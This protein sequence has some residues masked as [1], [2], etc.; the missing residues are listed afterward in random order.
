MPR[1]RQQSCCPHHQTTRSVT[2]RCSVSCSSMT[3]SRLRWKYRCYLTKDD[4]GYYRS[5]GFELEFD[6]DVITGHIDFLQI[7][8][9]NIHILDYKPDAGKE[10]RANCWSS[11]F[12]KNSA[13][14]RRPNQHQ[15]PPPIQTANVRSFIIARLKPQ[16][17]K[18]PQNQSR[19]TNSESLFVARTH[20]SGVRSR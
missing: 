19:F 18:E 12:P 1:A 20:P 2:R 7:R 4:L 16:C 14:P 13:D 11:T 15:E 10:R 6:S 17:R 8:N 9:G 5:R 3:R